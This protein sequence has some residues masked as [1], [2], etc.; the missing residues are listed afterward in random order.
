[1]VQQRESNINKR[2]SVVESLAHFI[3]HTLTNTFL[4][5]HKLYDHILT[6][7]WPYRLKLQNG[8]HVEFEP[9]GDHSDTFPHFVTAIPIIPE[10]VTEIDI[11]VIML[12][13]TLIVAQKLSL[14]YFGRPD[15]YHINMNGRGQ[16]SMPNL[17]HAH[18]HLFRSREKRLKYFRMVMD[19][20]L[21]N[22]E[23]QSA[24]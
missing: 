1:M 23:N 2:T 10:S 15:L 19:Q 7:N 21:S 9:A 5:K 14:I 8:V 24:I 18:I 13:T 6:N 3:S 12:S 20:A 16:C 17:A 22:L 11:D 4:K